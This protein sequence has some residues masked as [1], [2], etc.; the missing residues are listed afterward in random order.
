[1]SKIRFENIRGTG[2]GT[3]FGVV[4]VPEFGYLASITLLVAIVFVIILIKKN[5]NL[6]SILIQK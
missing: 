1:V 6:K 4:V 3:E 2:L 5:S